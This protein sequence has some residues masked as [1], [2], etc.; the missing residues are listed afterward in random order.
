MINIHSSLICRVARSSLYRLPCREISCSTA[1]CWRQ[2]KG[3]YNIKY[4]GTMESVSEDLMNMQ[5]DPKAKYRFAGVYVLAFFIVIV[6][7]DL[8]ILKDGK[9]SNCNGATACDTNDWD[10]IAYK[11]PY[12]MC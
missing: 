6:M 1:L 9:M 3:R 12:G 11:N 8:D 5:N 2:K 7:V 10:K 4:W